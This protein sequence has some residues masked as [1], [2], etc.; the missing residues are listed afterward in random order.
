VVLIWS[1]KDRTGKQLDSLG[2]WMWAND[3]YD[4]SNT[5]SGGLLAAG[6][7]ISPRCARNARPAVCTNCIRMK[8]YNVWISLMRYQEGSSVLIPFYQAKI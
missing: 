1:L 3:N 4:T 6:A 5:G 8:S 2:R 7:I